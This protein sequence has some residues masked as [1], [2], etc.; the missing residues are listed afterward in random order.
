MPQ[1]AVAR[2]VGGVDYAPRIVLTP[3]RLRAVTGLDGAVELLQE[4]GF[5]GSPRSIDAQELGPGSL[6]TNRVLKSSPGS[7]RGSAVFIA[8]LPSR[9]RSLRTLGRCLL[10]N[11]H[12]QPL[13]VLGIRGKGQRW[14]RFIVVRPSWIRGVLGAVRVAKLEVDVSGP[15]RHDAE[16]LSSLAWAGDDRAAQERID[17]ALDVEAVTRRF[18]LQLGGHHE[19]SPADRAAGDRTQD[20]PPS[21]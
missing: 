20:R 10:Q 21:G 9:P 18:Y 13:G 11:F 14:E 17:R 12:D 1:G 6:A 8:E 3:S 5:R 19:S 16:V 4:L 2:G 15:T 7:S